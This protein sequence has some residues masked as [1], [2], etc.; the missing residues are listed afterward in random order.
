MR[1]TKSPRLTKRGQCCLNAGCGTHFSKEWNNID[2]IAHS[3]FVLQWDVKQDLPYPD[4]TFDAIY[5]SHLLEHLTPGNAEKLMIEFKRVLKPGGILRIVVPDL[6]QICREYIKYLDAFS[7]EPS[8]R[9]R[10]RYEWSVLALIDQ[11]AR[12]EPGGLMLKKIKQGDFDP[13]YLRER[14]SLRPLPGDVD[15]NDGKRMEV[16][17]R[18][19]SFLR[20][21]LNGLLKYPR[22]IKNIIIGEGKVDPREIGEVHRWMYDKISL[23]RLFEYC[24]YIDFR[25][26]NHDQSS[27]KDW[28]EY[29]FDTADD[30]HNPRKPDSIFTEAKK[31]AV[32]FP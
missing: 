28:S 8:E 19:T 26:L 25:T 24:G 27:I 4:N 30:G 29:R 12:E 11:I 5:S 9:N 23:M 20:D 32:L 14:S 10:Q 16:Q 21:V 6:E 7:R 1:N 18:Q 3:E 2:L 31:P 17:K 22:V 15:K 13:D